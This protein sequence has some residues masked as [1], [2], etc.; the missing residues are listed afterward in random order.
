MHHPPCPGQVPSGARGG[1]GGSGEDE[2]P[3]H[4]TYALYQ[5]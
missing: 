1:L 3:R 4:G 2:V 5:R